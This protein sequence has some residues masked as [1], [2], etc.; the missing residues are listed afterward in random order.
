M[1]P[2][3]KMQAR[4]IDQLKILT[5]YRR[6]RLKSLRSH[7]SK[8]GGV[9]RR[10]ANSTGE[11]LFVLLSFQSDLGIINCNFLPYPPGA[12]LKHARSQL[13]MAL[14]LEGCVLC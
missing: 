10:K 7:W 14:A 1:R 9:E 3:F 2:D 6:L 11:K 13:S 4:F 12:I 5:S 8:C